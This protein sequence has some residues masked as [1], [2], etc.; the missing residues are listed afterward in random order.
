VTTRNPEKTRK[1]LIEAGFWEIYRSG[2]QA[3]RLPVILKQAGVTRGALYH[4][5][6]G[7]LELGYAV[8]DEVVEPLIMERWVEPLSKVD[9]PIAALRGI[10]EG[11]EGNVP[12]GVMEYGCP[13]N[14]LAQEM[15]PIDEGFRI[16]IDRAF[17]NW[18]AQLKAAL[19]RGRE[20]GYLRKDI[21]PA[22]VSAF[23]LALLEG[24]TGWMKNKQNPRVFR[25]ITAELLNYLESL[26]PAVAA[27]A[28][29]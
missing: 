27:E 26:K 12:P 9:D 7:K 10:I 11:F 1:D 4:Y 15:S 2:Y 19:A 25:D 18:H 21:D 13:L 24:T 5:F 6:P 29:R 3:A 14:N 8:F 17:A 28:T 20:Q 22:R 16:R 23:I